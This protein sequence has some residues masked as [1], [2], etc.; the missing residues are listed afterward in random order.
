VSA[1]RYSEFDLS[2]LTVDTYRARVFDALLGGACALFGGAAVFAIG[3]AA[4]H[5]RPRGLWLALFV[6]AL[7]ALFFLTGWN[8]VAKTWWS[9]LPTPDRLFLVAALGLAA[10]RI[11][12][13]G[14]IGIVPKKIPLWLAAVFLLVPI[15]LTVAAGQMRSSR[16]EAA[17]GKPNFLFLIV[18]AL[19]ADHMG[20]HGYHRNTTPALDRLAMQGYRF[21]N[22]VS[23]SLATRYTVASIFTMAFPGVHGIRRDGQRLSPR[24]VTVAEHLREA[25]YDTAA[26]APNPSIKAAFGY[27]QGF[28]RYDDQILND[29]RSAPLWDQFETAKRINKRATG[30]IRERGDHPWFIYIHYRD[31]HFPYA[32]P[33]DYDGMFYEP[34]EDGK[35]HRAITEEEYARQPGGEMVDGDDRNDLEYYIA[36]YDASIRYNDDQIAAFL[37]VLREEGHL[38]N[39]VII[40]SADHG[41][42]FLEHGRWNHGNVI[43]DEMCHVPGIIR[44][45]DALEKPVVIDAP[46]HTFDFSRT[47]LDMAGVPAVGTVQAK[48]LVPL[49]NGGEAPWEYAFV[50]KLSRYALRNAQWKY[51]LRESEKGQERELYDLTT[52]PGE[53]KDLVKLREDTAADLRRKILAIIKLNEKLAADTNVEEVELSEDDRRELESLGYL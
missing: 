17:K 13:P 50:E 4:F 46:V 30:W 28:D 27:G 47:I 7:G 48:S 33:P 12:V 38:D 51:I 10:E 21:S 18:D 34:R 1:E 14:R 15:G 31:P 20:I 24:F 5:A 39:T 45:P 35:P 23:N 9:R 6:I 16:T 41:E 36:Q 2:L 40:V 3:R 32:P 52:D 26:W 8:S 44:M 25:G 19:R 37:S 53:T 42:G 11:L 29:D 43:Y 22:T 49:M